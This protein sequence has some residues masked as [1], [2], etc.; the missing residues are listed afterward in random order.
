MTTPIVSVQERV[1]KTARDTIEGDDD[2]TIVEMYES[3]LDVFVEEI[4]WKR[5]RAVGEGGVDAEKTLESVLAKRA[6]L[7][8]S[9]RNLLENNTKKGVL[10]SRLMR[11]A[12]RLELTEKETT[13]LAFVLVHGT[14]SPTSKYLE[15]RPAMVNI[16]EFARMSA[17]E[18][19]RFTSKERAHVK[20]GIVEID[21]GFTKDFS[22]AAYKM[23]HEVMLALSGA[24]LS[25]DEFL[26]V[27]NTALAEVLLEEKTL[28]IASGDEG[29]GVTTK[30]DEDANELPDD[31]EI[32]KA[33]E[34]EMAALGLSMNNAEEEGQE[35]ETTTNDV[36]S[37]LD[38]LDP[39]KDDL[40]YLSDAFAV[41]LSRIKLYASSMEDEA[42]SLNN[43][44]AKA[45]QRELDAKS[46]H[47]TSRWER[48][49]QLTLRD[50]VGWLPRLERLAKKLDLNAFEKRV[51]LALA[52]VVISQD[53]RK[54]ANKARFSAGVDVGTVLGILCE[55]LREQIHSRRYF[56]RNAKLIRE[57]IV[58]VQDRRFGKCDLNDCSIELDRRMLDYIVGLDTELSEMCEGKYDRTPFSLSCR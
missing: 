58:R 43:R 19:L 34:D 57:G 39:Y 27:D 44:S 50:G 10:G 6:D 9:L 28:S 5:K 8:T 41:V 29:E 42:L 1:E 12:N 51:V 45:I 11:L 20:Q 18:F 32:A 13:A 35:E 14:A 17:R 37:S 3:M 54:E 33:I 49:T 38:C 16:R 22:E 26:R 23:P 15:S 24:T 2:V 53:I 56:Y 30:T 7:E 4:E 40:E 21:D 55:G 25:T 31:E 52:G 46:R 48:R 47:A 36:E